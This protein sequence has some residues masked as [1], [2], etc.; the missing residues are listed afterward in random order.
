MVFNCSRYGPIVHWTL[1]GCHQS[2]FTD[3]LGT[4]LEVEVR[5]ITCISTICLFCETCKNIMVRS[6][7]THIHTLQNTHHLHW[8]HHYEGGDFTKRKKTDFVHLASSD[9]Q[10]SRL[11]VRTFI[12]YRRLNWHWK[13]DLVYPCILLPVLLFRMLLLILLDHWLLNSWQRFEWTTCAVM[14]GNQPIRLGSST[15]CMMWTSWV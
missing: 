10:T 2:L 5:G 12:C 6:T 15:K 7:H 11:Y 14:S 1:R 3:H 4:L 9:L 13:K 8:N